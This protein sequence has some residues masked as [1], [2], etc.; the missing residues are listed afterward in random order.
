MKVAVGGASGM[1]GTALV[2]ELERDGHDVVR[3]VRGETPPGGR[4]LR[5]D[6]ATGVVDAAGLEG[7]DA[8]VNLAG[9]SLADGRWTDEKKTRIFESR[10]GGTRLLAGALAGL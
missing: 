8:V 1:V 10:A 6:P 9:E 4:T 3:L 5:W 2:A 7:L